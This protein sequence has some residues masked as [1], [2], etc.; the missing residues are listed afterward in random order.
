M[1]KKHTY[2]L[3]IILIFIV[4]IVVGFFIGISFNENKQSINIELADDLNFL[5]SFINIFGRNTFAFLVL[6]SSVFLGKG[7]AYFFYVINGYILGLLISKFSSLLDFITILPHGIIEM[8]C[9]ILAGYFFIC[10]RVEGKILFIKYAGLTYLGLLISA[11]IES[12]IT[13]KL[14]ILL[15]Q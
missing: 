14:I 1:I 11:I 5:K 2:L 6:L 8:G 10:Y 9:F 3:K 15:Y 13:P 12:S 4:S 7:I